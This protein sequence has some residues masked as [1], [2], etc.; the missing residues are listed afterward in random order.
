MNG[1]VQAPRAVAKANRAGSNE[2]QNLVVGCRVFR[3]GFGTSWDLQ[4]VCCLHGRSSELQKTSNARPESPKAPF[5]SPLEDER[6]ICLRMLSKGTI[7]SKHPLGSS[8]REGAL[9][10]TLKVLRHQGDIAKLSTIYLKVGST[11]Q[12]RKRNR[13]ETAS[14]QNTSC[15]QLVK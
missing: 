13:V 4:L 2:K 5:L 15:F 3:L 14:G 7:H 9:A 6:R 1:R 12:E 8:S 10:K 11:L